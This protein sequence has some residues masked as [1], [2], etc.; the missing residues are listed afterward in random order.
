M[1]TPERIFRIY[2]Y[3]Y[4]H[5]AE[6]R[7]FQVAAG[8][9]GFLC[10]PGDARELAEALRRALQLDSAARARL[11]EAAIAWAHQHYDKEAMCRAVLAVYAEVLAARQE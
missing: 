9:T 10:A 3:L 6:I 8:E 2:K 5:A 11:Y 7:D 4:D 1:A